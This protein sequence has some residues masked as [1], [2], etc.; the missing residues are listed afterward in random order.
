MSKLLGEFITAHW[1]TNI[2]TNIK[3]TIRTWNYKQA[4]VLCTAHKMKFSIKDFLSKCDQ[5]LNEKLHF[6]Y[7]H[8]P[9]DQK[10]YI[11][12]CITGTNKNWYYYH[13]DNRIQIFFLL[14]KA[15]KF[16]NSRNSFNPFEPEF[17]VGLIFFIL[18]ASFN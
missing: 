4:F 8:N 6:L 5:I 12:L 18:A 3:V 11:F 16:H 7:S 13:W 14:Y 2:S 15:V 17:N 9:N 10:E 1:I